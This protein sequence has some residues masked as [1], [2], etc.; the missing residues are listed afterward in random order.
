METL[1][2][3]S[4]PEPRPGFDDELERKLFAAR[5][6]RWPSRLPRPFLVAAATT[7]AVLAGVLGLSLAGSGPLSGSDAGVQA[8]T[9]CSLVTVTKRTRVPYIAR[10]ADGELRIAYRYEKRK[11]QVRRCP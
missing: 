8:T 2:R 11:R 9:N 6:A 4:R 1:L 3:N 10:S 5:S 7:T